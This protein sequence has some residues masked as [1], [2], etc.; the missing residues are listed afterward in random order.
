M[1]CVCEKANKKVFV[2]PAGSTQ[3]SPKYVQKSKIEV[4]IHDL[5]EPEVLDDP[6]K[7][8]LTWIKTQHFQSKL[9]DLEM[10]SR[11][12]KCNEQVKLNV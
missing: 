10:M 12:L 3:L 11:S 8:Q 1:N 7:F 5:L 9:F 2:N 4:Y 6:T